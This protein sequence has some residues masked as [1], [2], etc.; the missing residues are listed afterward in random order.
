MKYEKIK[1]SIPYEKVGVTKLGEPAQLE[2]YILKTG[3]EKVRPAILICPGGGY[4]RVSEREGECI[5]LQ[6]MAMGYHAFVLTYSVEP[7]IWPC[8]LLE[9]A[10]SMSLIRKHSKEWQIDSNKI[11][12][13]GFS[14]GGHLAQCLATFWNQPFLYETLGVDKEEIRPNGAVL[15]YPV[16]TSGEF[17]HRLSFERLLNG[18]KE[19]Y[20]E[21]TSLEKQVGEQNPPTFLWHTYE[22]QSVPVENSLLLAMSLREKKI[23]LELHIFP[24][25]E[26]GLSLATKETGIVLESVQPWMQLVKTWLENL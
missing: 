5:A 12:V 22:D 26:H 24:K 18:C 17:A 25:G 14:A 6:Y 10:T 16:I 4:Q 19:E 2:A 8:A 21:L 13:Q 11:I 9:L 15:C 3:E 1:L 20:K 23:P 7:N